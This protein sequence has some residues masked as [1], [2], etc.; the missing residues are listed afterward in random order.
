MC[1]D[2]FVSKSQCGRICSQPKWTTQSQR[3]ASKGS[4]REA[5][6]CG[7]AFSRALVEPHVQ[8]PPQKPQ[9]RFPCM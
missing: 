6:E 3:L 1:L 2:G 9:N 7:I 4:A 5:T 8:L